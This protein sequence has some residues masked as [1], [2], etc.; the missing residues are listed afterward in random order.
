MSWPK[1]LERNWFISAHN[2]GL[3]Y[4]IEGKSQELEFE[5]SRHSQCID[6]SR[7]DECLQA[8]GA[9]VISLFYLQSRIQI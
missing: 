7:E 5:T 1:Q 3:Q 2:F 9:W 6:K 4:I 8:P